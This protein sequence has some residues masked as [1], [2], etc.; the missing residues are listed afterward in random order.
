[1]CGIGDTVAAFF[2]IFLEKIGRNVSRKFFLAL[3]IMI[4]INLFN[5]FLIFKTF[6]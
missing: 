1:M 2:A 3:V 5:L 4:P 6:Y